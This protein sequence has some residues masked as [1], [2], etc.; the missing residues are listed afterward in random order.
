MEYTRTVSERELVAFGDVITRTLDTLVKEVVVG[1]GVVVVVVLVL[2]DVETDG[3]RVV[4]VLLLDG[5]AVEAVDAVEP[6]GAAVDAVEP[7]VPAGVEAE[8]DDS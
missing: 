7:V 1:E 4:D 3:A 5:A 6:L 2:G 8:L